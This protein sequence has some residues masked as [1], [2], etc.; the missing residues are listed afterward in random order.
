MLELSILLLH[1]FSLNLIFIHLFTINKTN[2]SR[3]TLSLIKN[4]Y[5]KINCKIKHF[6]QYTTYFSPIYE[7]ICFRILFE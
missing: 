1:Y 5:L 7:K 2:K 4:I 6:M 3:F